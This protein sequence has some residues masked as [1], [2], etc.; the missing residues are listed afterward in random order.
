M[1]ARATPEFSRVIA[2]DRQGGV[3]D[4]AQ[5]FEIEA[6]PAER[7]ALARRFGLL[8]LERLEASGRIEVL[9][10]GRRARLVARLSGEVTQNCVV[11]LEAVTSRIDETFVRLYEKSVSPESG[12]VEIDPEAEDPPEPLPESGIDV[13]EAVAEQL[14]LAI[15]PYPRAPG[16]EFGPEGASDDEDAEAEASPFAVLKHLRR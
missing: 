1:T 8:S 10:P 9:E 15:D 7:A 11:T 6:T 2:L 14:G 5:R 12:E 13:G 3:G 4:E 16:A